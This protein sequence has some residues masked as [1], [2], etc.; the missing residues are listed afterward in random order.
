MCWDQADRWTGVRDCSA[1]YVL[2]VCMPASVGSI[3][4]WRASVE[5]IIQ[6]RALISGEHQWRASESMESVREREEVLVL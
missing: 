4:Q 3:I 2:T 6:W 1:M 5:S